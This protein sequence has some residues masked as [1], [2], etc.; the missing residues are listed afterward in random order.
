M[1]QLGLPMAPPV[2]NPTFGSSDLGNVGY[3]YP[4]FN[5][6]FPV[7]VTAALHS[8]LFAVATKGDDAWKATVQAAKVVALTAW[9][10]LNDPAKVES[11]KNTFNAMKGK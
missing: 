5:I 4:T 1:A 8:D 10:L 6:S 7:P 9:D 3:A 11:I 2:E